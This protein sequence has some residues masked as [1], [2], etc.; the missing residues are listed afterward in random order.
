MRPDNCVNLSYNVTWDKANCP[1]LEVSIG[2]QVCQ[3]IGPPPPPPCQFD[4]N[5]YKWVR[6]KGTVTNTQ[7]PT[8][9]PTYQGYQGVN[10]G[11]D[12][13]GTLTSDWY[14]LDDKPDDFAPMIMS[15]YMMPDPHSY[16]YCG[17][18]LGSSPFS[19]L[20][21]NSSSGGI[22]TWTEPEFQK[23]RSSVTVSTSGHRSSFRTNLYIGNICWTDSSGQGI[24]V[25]TPNIP[26]NGHVDFRTGLNI[27]PYPEVTQEETAVIDGVWEFV[28]TEN[29]DQGEILARWKGLDADGNYI[30]CPTPT[31]EPEPPEPC[32]IE[33]CRKVIGHGVLERDS[34]NGDGWTVTFPGPHRL[35]GE[36]QNATEIV[37]VRT[38]NDNIGTYPWYLI[39]SFKVS[40]GDNYGEKFN[41]YTKEQRDQYKF[42][43]V[44]DVASSSTCE[45]ENCDP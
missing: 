18:Y 37:E 6:F 43:I 25:T 36:G 34:G 16:Q 12:T 1:K 21:D 19:D 8:T 15:G 20:S 4:P 27:A 9:D 26:L 3:P 29:P 45:I 30:D 14:H 23:W 39:I 22:T 44:P 28:N 35:Y 42:R 17:K 33:G 10:Y 31:P 24:N 32:Q 40:S 11:I 41:F 38:G 5:N 2:A 7:F 13:D